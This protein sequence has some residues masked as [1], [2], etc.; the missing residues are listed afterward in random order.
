MLKLK[1][2]LI[3]MMI[4]IAGCHVTIVPV[5]LACAW[6]KPITT[7]ETDRKGM[8]RPLKEQVAT[9]NELWDRR[10]GE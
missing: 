10:C 1:L 3:P 6:V 4:L 9:H 8:T 5:D 2:L 7:S